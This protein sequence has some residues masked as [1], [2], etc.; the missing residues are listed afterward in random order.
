MKFKLIISISL[1][2]VACSGSKVVLT[3]SQLRSKLEEHIA[4]LS[5]DEFEGRESGEP[6]ALK[7]RDYV[8]DQFELINLKPKGTK[9]FVQSF[10]FPKGARFGAS[11]Q[12]YINLYSFQPDTD[13]VPLPYSS[14]GIVT[15][16]IARVGYG[17]DDPGL[18]QQDYLGKVNLSKKIFVMEYGTPDGNNPHGKF[19]EWT[20]LRKRIDVAISRGAVGV[21]FI[22]SD[23]SITVPIPD[24][25]SRITASAIPVIFAKGKSAEL[26]RDSVIT[27]CTV[28]VEIERIQKTA[29]NV[30]GFV[31]NKAKNTIV[32]G[33]HYD[34]L[35]YGDEGSL[36]RGDRAI[37]NGAD[38][39]A[40]GTAAMIELGRR[41]KISGPKTNNYLFIAFSGEEKGLLGS[42]Y[43]VKNSPVDLT[44]VNYMIN[45]D[46]VGRL[47]ADDKTLILSGTGT[48]PRF[49]TLIDSI[50]VDSIR[51]KP[52]D[53][54]VGPSDHT[55]FYLQ[56]VPV[57][58]FFSGT[59]ADYH[60]PS[61]DADRINY[62]GEI[63][64]MKI[65]L[66]TINLTANDGKIPF[67]KTKDEN[68]ENAPKFK[69]T[70]G[71]VPDY[72]YDGEG[73]RIDG[74]TDGKPASKA[75]LQPGD[76]V[77]QIGEHRVL[78]MM[79]YM[80]ALGKFNRG[81][82][83]KIKIRRGNQELE[84]DVVF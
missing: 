68:N 64:I 72:T 48:S 57:L 30:V 55:S 17:I 24:F 26:L 54:G 14:N 84:K 49:K 52:S 20:D 59:H 73:M 44:T 33:A 13:F 70:L 2:L 79:S 28:G 69:V 65:I 3:D 15:G 35:G 41:L 76:V 23:T 61:D 40:S 62:E 5:S 47:K 78:D 60:K 38:D 9:G 32:I 45:L 12:L 51:I 29:Y 82:A 22:N 8:V 75:G 7:A 18:Q 19:T 42:N 37:H 63:A 58:H 77:V 34:H 16:Y 6:G 56:N 81:D 4:I 27:N 83:V 43:F 50:S 10:T 71:V 1:F 25:N 67:T 21:I 66:N 53:S 39:N 11:T 36:Y 80:K 74:V 46:M 31:N